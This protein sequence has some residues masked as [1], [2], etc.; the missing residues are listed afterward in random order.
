MDVNN[1][2][3][4]GCTTVERLTCTGPSICDDL[5]VKFGI[6]KQS[7]SKVFHF[8]SLTPCQHSNPIQ[9]GKM[10]EGIMLFI[11]FRTVVSYSHGLKRS[12]V[13]EPMSS[14]TRNYLLAFAYLTLILFSL[15]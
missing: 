10:S 14:Q 2:T 11:P 7:I 12:K 6:A 15:A 3:M 1:S 4:L 5:Q 8:I 13:L 9:M